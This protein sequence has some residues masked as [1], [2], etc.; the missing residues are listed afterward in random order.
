MLP[1]PCS[2]E[3]TNTN[4]NSGARPPF[5]SDDGGET[6]LDDLLKLGACFFSATRSKHV[7]LI[8]FPLLVSVFCVYQKKK[9]VELR[10]GVWA[11][12]SYYDNDR[13]P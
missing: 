9:C 8:V 2:A 1:V 7:D 11:K 5:L 3:L 6:D 10:V 13:A 12:L 4:V